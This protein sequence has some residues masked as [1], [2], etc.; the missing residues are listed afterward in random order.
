M[1]L[2]K[3]G[4]FEKKNLLVSEVLRSTVNSLKPLGQLKHVILE[5]SYA[6]SESEVFADFSSLEQVFRNLL[7]N[8]VHATTD[9]PMRKITVGVNPSDDGDIVEAFVS[10]NG[11]GIN[12]D[13]IDKIFDQYFSTKKE[14]MGTGLGLS[15]VKE[16][17]E[18]VHGGKVSV[19][20]KIDK[21]TVFKVLLPAVDAA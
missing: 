17:I 3:S 15:V 4:E 10:D 21:G 18:V 6:S 20:S 2:G 19:E 12:P 8:A 9:N 16:I 14:D 7:L 13:I 11:S 5:E 1:N